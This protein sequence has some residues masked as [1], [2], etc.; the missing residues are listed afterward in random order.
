MGRTL[1][2]GIVAG[3]VVFLW[4][5]LAHMAL[6]LGMQG[7]AIPEQPAQQAMLGSLRENLTSEG[8]YM[9][10]MPPKEQWD[11]EA[12]MTAF[13]ERATQQ[14]YAFLVFQPQGRDINASF[15]GLLLRQLGFD[16]LAGVLAAFVAAAMVASRM[17]RAFLVSSLGLFSWLSLAAPYWNWY[18]FP[19]EF[20]TAALIEEVV[21]WALAGLAITFI[22]KPREA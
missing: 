5:A 9:L 12:A 17:R 6:P 3:I 22:L 21:G 2:A 1:V 15:P 14:P 4:G 16:V 7:F 11:D 18:R 19:T 10:P 8:V 20:I 13:G